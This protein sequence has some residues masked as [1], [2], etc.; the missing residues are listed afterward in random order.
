MTLITAYRADDKLAAKHLVEEA[1]TEALVSKC[2][3]CKRLFVKEDGCNKM[4]CRCG[5]LQCYVCGANVV[6]NY[7]HFEGGR[8][9]LYT[10]MNK[11][12]RERV[13]AAQ[14]R[15]VQDLLK[16]RA[17]LNDNDVRVDKREVESITSDNSWGTFR[18][19]YLELQQ[20]IFNDDLGALHRRP[21]LGAVQ[22]GGHRPNI[23][24]VHKCRPCGKSF[25]SYTSLSQHRRAKHPDGGAQN[26]SCCICKKSFHSQ[27]SLSQHIRD[28]QK[29]PSH[30]SKRNRGVSSGPMRKRMRVH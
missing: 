25:G 26:T 12:L 17:E 18:I 14:E 30:A 19:P 7:S 11:I 22:N 16:D 4:T 5:N 1:M 3:N 29:D 21:Q 24:G 2:N 6:D 27:V 15:T 8:C 23:G 13:A 28:K 20:N 10:D 9:E